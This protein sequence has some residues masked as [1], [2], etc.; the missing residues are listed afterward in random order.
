MLG[1]VEHPE[2]TGTGPRNLG[3]E[4]T[5]P[6]PFPLSVSLRSRRSSLGTR[7]TA[8]PE[9]TGAQLPGGC[10]ELR[11]ASGLLLSQ[12]FSCIYGCSCCLLGPPPLPVHCEHGCQC[13][14]WHC[15]SVGAAVPP[16]CC[17]DAQ[18]AQLHWLVS[19]EHLPH[20]RGWGGTGADGS[21][22]TSTSCFGGRL[23]PSA[24]DVP[25]SSRCRN[26]GQGKTPAGL[27]GLCGVN[28]T[29]D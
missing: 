3:A 29:E 26:T 5:A 10:P 2:L 11:S 21:R 19:G 16:A 13:R 9:H 15:D 8:L 7:G 20:T 1:W 14:P 4:P 6:S 12:G 17:S 18:F 27:A 22:V 23:C 25:Y 28:T 24:P